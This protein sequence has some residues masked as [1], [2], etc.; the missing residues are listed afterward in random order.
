[1]QLKTYLKWMEKHNI[2]FEWLADY[3]EPGYSLS[4]GQEGILLANWNEVPNR[5]QEGLEPHA[6]LVWSDEWAAC[7]ECGRA[8]RT[9]PDSYQWTPSFTL[10]NDCE[11]LCLDCQADL[12]QEDPN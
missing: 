3:A 11:I 9:S 12:P 1:M 6:E 8:V 2:G 4:E 5:I 10:H 7:C